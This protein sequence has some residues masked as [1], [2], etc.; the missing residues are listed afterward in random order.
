MKEKFVEEDKEDIYNEKNIGE[1]L[2]G[3][4]INGLEEG[5]MLGYIG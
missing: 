4:E 5:F 1:Y 2:E 3:D